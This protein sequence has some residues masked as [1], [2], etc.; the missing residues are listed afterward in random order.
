MEFAKVLQEL[1]ERHQRAF[2]YQ[3][4]PVPFDR[5]FSQDG[6]LSIFVRRADLLADFLFGEKLKVSYQSDPGTLTGEQVI[7]SPQQ[8]LFELVM[9]LYDVLEEFIVNAGNGD[10]VLS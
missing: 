3:N 7:I 5:L 10:V 8:K 9:L 6:T 1:A 2:L 4:E